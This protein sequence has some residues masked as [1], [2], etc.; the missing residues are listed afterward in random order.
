MTMNRNGRTRGILVSTAA[1]FAILSFAPAVEAQPRARQNRQDRVS[2][3]GYQRMRQFAREL[4]ERAADANRQAQADQA[5]YRG[6]RRDT[7]FLNSIRDFAQRSRA[8]RARMETYQTRTW[9]VD[10]EI[11]ILLR[12][13]RNVQTRIGRARYADARTRQEWAEVVDLLGNLRDEYLYGGRSVRN[14]NEL[15]H[16]THNLKNSRRV[17][18]P[19]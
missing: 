12:D 15:I 13:A 10:E 6:V 14:R 18:C 8:F 7:K 9:N 17:S 2:N 5:G 19:M 3:A 1:L 4:D 16:S 11:Q